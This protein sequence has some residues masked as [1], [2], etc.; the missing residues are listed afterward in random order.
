MNVQNIT[1][2]INDTAFV[3]R[4]IASLTN[5]SPLAPSKSQKQIMPHSFY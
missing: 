1:D 4:A 3:G 5:K 2:K